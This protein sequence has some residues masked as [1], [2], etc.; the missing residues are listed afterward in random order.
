MLSAKNLVKEHGTH[1]ALDDVSFEVG[2]GEIFC[3]LGANG[4]GKSTTIKLFLGFLTPT[5]GSAEVDGLSAHRHPQ[6]V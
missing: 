2:P 5:S 6:E 3:L 4:A 1:R